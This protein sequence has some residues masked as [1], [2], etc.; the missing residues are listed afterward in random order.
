MGQY[1]KMFESLLKQQFSDQRCIE[2]AIET[3]LR[4]QETGLSDDDIILIAKTLAADPSATVLNSQLSVDNDAEIQ[5]SLTEEDLNDA[6]EL[7]KNAIPDVIRSTTEHIAPEMLKAMNTESQSTIKLLK[8]DLR[9]FH[10]SIEHAWGPALDSLELFINASQEA[11][12]GFVEASQAWDVER[13]QNSRN[14]AAALVR[15][16]IRACRTAS[17]IL[18]LLR[19]GFS[20]GA[21]ARWRSL[22]EL[23]VI[24]MYLSEEPDSV[25]EMYLDHSVIEQAKD[26]ESYVTHCEALGEEPVE[27][28]DVDALRQ[29]RDNLKSKYGNAFGGDYGWA[30]CH[31]KENFTRFIDIEKSVPLDHWRP[32]YKLACQSIHAGSRGCFFSLGALSEDDVPSA[33]TLAGL[34]DPGQNCAIF[35]LMSSAALLTFESSLDQ[36]IAS[37]ILAKMCGQVTQAFADRKQFLD[38]HLIE[39]PEDIFEDADD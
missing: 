25:S 38:D 30:S 5:I 21:N 15:I 3:S 28:Q 31:R 7:M 13:I 24:S 2:L 9:S 6:I 27:D 18:C 4:K 29:A 8:D 16:H 12:Y 10:E 11:R 1:Q 32:Y 14:K 37:Q 17:E 35:L 22:Y 26:L 23:A 39:F 19:G 34:N 33:Q 36:L 20:D